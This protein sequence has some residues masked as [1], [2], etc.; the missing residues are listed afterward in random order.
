MRSRVGTSAV[1]QKKKIRPIC[2][3][4]AREYSQNAH[5]SHVTFRLWQNDFFVR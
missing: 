4:A 1:Y 2:S 5:G 3:S